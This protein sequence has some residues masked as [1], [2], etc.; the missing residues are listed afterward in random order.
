MANQIGLEAVLQDAQFQA[1]LKDYISGVQEMV[2]ETQFA[3]SAISQ[4]LVGI[5]NAF[6]EIGSIITGAVVGAATTAAVAIGG[7]ISSGVALA[8]DLEAQLDTVAGIMGAT[9]EEAAMLGALIDDLGLDPNLKVSATEAATAIEAL[10]RNGV[11]LEDILNGAARATVL[12]ANATGTDFASAANTAT[13]VLEL[14]GFAATELET[15]V[16]GIVGV[17]T[18]SKFSF[19]DYALALSNAGG[20]AKA[21]GLSFNDFNATLATTSSFFASGA[22]AG[23]SLNSFLLSLQ[24]NTEK[25]GD[26]FRELGLITADG[27]NQFFDAAGALKSMDEIIVVLQTA[28][29]GMTNEQRTSVASTIFQREA[30][31]TVF[32]LL[33]ANAGAFAELADDIAGTSAADLAAQRMQNLAGA[34][35]ILG[36]AVETIQKQIGDLF[37]PLLTE[38]AN[39]ITEFVTNNQDSFVSFFQSIADAASAILPTV[40]DFVLNFIQAMI[41][42]GPTIIAVTGAVLAFGA[43]LGP[44]LIITGSIVSSIGSLIPVFTAVS[45]AITA[46]TVPAIASFL[47]A[48]LPIVGAVLAVVAVMGAFATAVAT[49]FGGLRDAVVSLVGVIVGGFQSMIGTIA[50]AVGAIASLFGGTLISSMRQFAQFISGT[51]IPIVGDLFQGAFAIASAVL[52]NL[53]DRLQSTLLPALTRLQ[54]AFS[55]YIPLVLRLASALGSGLRAALGLVVRVLAILIP[56]IYDA[57]SSFRFLEIA[58][59]LIAVA[60]ESFV[61]VVETAVVGIEYLASAFTTGAK[62]IQIAADAIGLASV[63]AS[64]GVS[65]VSK[66]GAEMKK[67]GESSAELG[68]K[69][70]KAGEQEADA[71]QESSAL[72]D[73]LA[74]LESTLADTESGFEDLGDSVN[75]AG[76][77][78]ADYYKEALQADLA[79]IDFSNTIGE[80]IDANSELGASYVE[81][82][83][84]LGNYSTT[85]QE[86]A[87]LTAE[88]KSATD[89]Y[90]EALNN[91]S[92]T[93]DQVRANLQELYGARVE[94]LNATILQEQANKRLA[95]TV[96]GALSTAF[97]SAVGSVGELAGAYAELAA[98]EAEL[99]KR[100][101]DKTLIEQAENARS[102]VKA[103]LDQINQAYKQ[104][105]FTIIADSDGV[106]DTLD[107]ELGQALGI[108]T[109]IEA[110][111]RLD[112]QK[113]Q[114]A[115]TA[116]F[117]SIESPNVP[118]VAALQTAVEAGEIDGASIDAI[119]EQIRAR[120]EAGAGEE[121]EATIQA[122]VALALQD[123]KIDTADVENIL[124]SIDASFLQD[125]APDLTAEVT[126]TLAATL[127]DSE[128]TR[129]KGL[130]DRATNTLRND[131]EQERL[132]QSAID[133]IVSGNVDASD[134]TAQLNQVLD[135]VQTEGVNFD[136]ALNI[137]IEAEAETAKAEA[138]LNQLKLLTGEISATDVNVDAYG[139]VIPATGP[140]QELKTLIDEVNGLS[141]STTATA[142][143]TGLDE[144]NQ[145]NDTLGDIEGKSASAAVGADAAEAAANIDNIETGLNNID[146]QSADV[147]A[148]FEDNISPNVTAAEARAEAAFNQMGQSAAAGSAAVNQATSENFVSANESVTSNTQTMA[149]NVN[150]GMTQISTDAAAASAGVNSSLSEISTG[151]AG[152]VSAIGGMVTAVSTALSSMVTSA[153][154]SSSGVQTAFTSANWSGIGEAISSGIA[155]GITA[156][157]G[158]IQ[159]AAKKAVEEAIAAAEEEAGIESPSKV[160]A[161]RVG[162]PISEGVAGGVTTA[163]PS[164]TTAMK[165]LVQRVVDAARVD[166]ANILPRAF[167]F[168]ENAQ[169]VVADEVGRIASA[170]VDSVRN[171]GSGRQALAP[172]VSAVGSVSPDILS[173]VAFGGNKSSTT[174]NNSNTSNYNL[175]NQT[176]QTNLQV[177]Q[178][179]RLMEMLN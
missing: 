9:A 75:L 46:I 148:T 103:K 29:A 10:A 132:I 178:A 26:A 149:Q 7:I 113:F 159:E 81:I 171:V 118:F 66:L 177:N 43:A 150:T 62:A 86:H 164:V 63:S 92:I 158:A 100:P 85:T 97:S 151:A 98:A 111:L 101:W 102:N 173:G 144:A 166:V 48:I 44:L 17:T 99:E 42:A 77:K 56:G 153:N 160:A 32:A 28:F 142:E 31:G 37:I 176:T 119:F 106:F 51:I 3:T 121:V 136:Q 35:E 68:G 11:E 71:A 87:M 138:D 146:G 127:D 23:T 40:V 5:G 126:A 76:E 174:I 41:N 107:A 133:V 34:M 116:L 22:Q 89:A 128:L 112:E 169:Q 163:T 165:S 2:G 4:G 115:I 147:T 60:L 109:P 59:T 179:F 124:R 47:A 95:D 141:A 170:V 139:N 52:K 93:I 15:A 21:T 168:P 172:I 154:A 61:Y 140:F 30:L 69:I 104:M 57:S 90:T 120:V 24:P 80:A 157:A 67:A 54:S 49:N 91:G 79:T 161:Q 14:F 73:A 143:V 64:D 12:L 72:D 38:L 25:A 175:N 88:I 131:F 167:S 58:I 108:F 36:G 145:L 39:K 55:A 84:S 50:P 125:L 129:L 27:K 13:D 19:N 156:N 114:N 18:A 74:M 130:F 137:L 45:T 117:G 16:D 70:A 53:S 122:A 8:S 78:F 94:D 96:S 6:T 134:V 83:S 82:T 152:V 162:E 110:Q 135:I 20:T 33:D 155:S 1:G 65:S 123:G 105:V